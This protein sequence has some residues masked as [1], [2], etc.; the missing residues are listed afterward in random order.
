MM[1]HE[2]KKFDHPIYVT[3]PLLPPVNGYMKEI[4]EIWET[5]W[6]TNGGKK[7]ARLESLLGSYLEN[8]N[9]SLFNNGTLAMIVACQALRLNGEVITTPFTFPAT[10]HVLAWNNIVPVFADIEPATMTLDPAA[11]EPLITARTTAILGVHVYGLPCHVDAIQ[12]IANLHGLKVVYDAAHAFG[13]RINGKSI[14]DFGDASMFS[15]HATKL[16]HTAEGGALVVRDA[17]IKERVDFLK[18]FGIR[19]EETVLLPGINGKMNELQ[20]ALGLLT[21]DM[22]DAERARRRQIDAL[23]RNNLRDVRGIMIPNLPPGVDGSYQYFPIRVMRGEAAVDRDQ[24]YDG[25]RRYN[26][27]GRKYFYP[28]CTEYACYRML[29]T[30]HPSFL[31]VAHTVASEILCLPFYGGL[32]DDDVLRIC[33]IIDFLCLRRPERSEVVTRAVAE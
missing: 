28:L 19:G 16:F 12:S 23:Y 31:P 32:T 18:N 26:V 13:T 7:H 27:Y 1:R 5:Q 11:I 9:I 4:E 21:F 33:E 6:L 20:A 30:A 8:S 15:F 14:A 29:P 2:P 3:R 24:I 22:I 25:L 17:Q 10:P